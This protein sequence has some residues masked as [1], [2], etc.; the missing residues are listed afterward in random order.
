M[1]Y[2]REIQAHSYILENVGVRRGGLQKKN[3]KT[4]EKKML[5]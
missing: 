2:G 1:A 4:K 5:I 3:R